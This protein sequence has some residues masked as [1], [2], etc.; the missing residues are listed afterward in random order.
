MSDEEDLEDFE[1]DQEDLDREDED[2]ETEEW[3]EDRKEEEDLSE[4]VRAWKWS[5]PRAK[6][7]VG[8][9]RDA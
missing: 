2:K 4:E 5:G 8:L 6:E 9:E 7:R 1:P 3:D